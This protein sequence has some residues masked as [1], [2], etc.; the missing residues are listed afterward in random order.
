MGRGLIFA[1]LLLCA[2]GCV[3]KGAKVVEGTDLAIGLNIP[4][5]DGALQLQLFNYLSGFRLGVAKNA[6][7]TVDYSVTETNSFMGIATTQITKSIKATVD[8][9][10]E[11]SE[12]TS[13]AEK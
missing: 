12:C 4:G 5:S 3:Y 8:P 13:N 10:E 9:L 1:A 11:K 6:R 2:A 7:L